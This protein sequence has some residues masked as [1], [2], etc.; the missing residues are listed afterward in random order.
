[1]K[2]LERL[3]LEF[4][5]CARGSTAIEYGLICALVALVVFTAIGQ[6]ADALSKLQI[7]FFPS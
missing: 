6:L 3:I 7:S 4:L 2:R 5:A 1:M